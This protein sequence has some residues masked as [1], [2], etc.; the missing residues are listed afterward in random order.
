MWATKHDIAIV[1]SAIDDV[2]R[3]ILRSIGQEVIMSA[4]LD[5]LKA[6]VQAQTGVVQ[7][8]S[9][10]LSGMAQQ[11]RDAAANNDQA[12]LDDLATQLETNTSALS[13]AVAANT[14][15]Q[16]QGDTGNGTAQG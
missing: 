4:S 9:T 2:K 3:L 10:L 13:A 8:V 16:S 1:L 15:A 6:D 7:S 12:A 11:I 5:K 14:P